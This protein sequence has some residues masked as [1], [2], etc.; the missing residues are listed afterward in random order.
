MATENAVR[1]LSNDELDA[2]SGGVVCVKESGF[3]IFG[4]KFSFYG[5][6]DGSYSGIG[7]RVPAPSLGHEPV[8]VG[9][10]RPA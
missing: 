4:I 10:P 6:D 2:V 8:H 1:A 3:T 5:C 7:E 9:G